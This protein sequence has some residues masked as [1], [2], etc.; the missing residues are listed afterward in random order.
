MSNSISDIAKNSITVLGSRELAEELIKEFD[1]INQRFLA[2]DFRPSELG[3]G[4]FSEV[5]F[6]VCQQQCKGSYTPVGS[7]LSRVDR[8][9]QELENAP[10]SGIDDTFRIHVPRSLR[11][12]YDLRNKRDVAHL[13]VGVSPN[14]A[15]SSLV[16]GCAAW[17]MAEFVRVGH[18]CDATEAQRIVDSLVQRRIPLVWADGDV[19]R[20]LRPALSYRDKTLLIL[21]HFHPDMVTPRQLFEWVGYSK[22]SKYQTSVLQTLHDD[23]LIHWRETDVRLLPPGL[24]YV[25]S[26][27]L[28]ETGL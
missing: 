25:E 21:Y 18:Q 1:E 8:L 10:S 26:Q 12:L 27:I 24:Q 13:G 9:I 11:L 2:A 16:I 6:R 28:T 20:V 3:G 4:R 19:V 22:Y 14:L 7:I 5:A 15:D 17:V 23:A